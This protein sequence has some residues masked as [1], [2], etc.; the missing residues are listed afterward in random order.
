MNWR[1]INRRE[2]ESVCERENVCMR[3]KERESDRK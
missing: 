1:K 3:E 2:R